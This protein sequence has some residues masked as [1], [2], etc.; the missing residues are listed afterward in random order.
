MDKTAYLEGYMHKEAKPGESAGS[1]WGALSSTAMPITSP[2]GNTALRTAG[3]FLNRNVLP[4]ARTG[5]KKGEAAI[6]NW[7]KKRYGDPIVQKYIK[8]KEDEIRTGMRAIGGIG[9]AGMVQNF[10]AQQQMQNMMR[11]Q[12]A[13]MMRMM[14]ARQGNAA[15]NPYQAMMA[16]QAFRR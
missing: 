9:L 7:L 16:Q 4:Y 8:P 15:A 14:Q 12:Y 2:V 6:G 5:L 11:Q 1:P 10:A 13:N 3:S